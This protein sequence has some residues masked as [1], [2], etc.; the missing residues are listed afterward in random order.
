MTEEPKLRPLQQPGDAP[1]PA[2]EREDEI[3]VLARTLWGEARGEG[4]AGMQAVALV[5]I[6][7]VAIARRRGGYWWGGDVIAV[8]RKPFQ[9]SCW[10]RSD[11]NRARLAGVDESDMHF[12]TAIRIARRAMLGFLKDETNGAT[13]YHARGITPDWARDRQACATI[14]RHI[15]Y[16][17]VKT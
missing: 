3:D 12:A 15:F 10:N 17:L 11:P 9:F 8:C 13:H 4:V 5:V 14:G 16:R 2:P 1:E 6:N 7:R